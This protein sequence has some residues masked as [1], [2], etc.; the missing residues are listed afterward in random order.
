[1]ISRH[2]VIAPGDQISVLFSR[3]A[4]MTTETE[5]ALMAAAAIMD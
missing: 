1:V 5:L 2:R 4:F 3:S